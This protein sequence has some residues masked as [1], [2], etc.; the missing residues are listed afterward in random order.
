MTLLDWENVIG[1]IELV[2]FGVFGGIAVIK[3]RKLATSSK[4]QGKDN[5]DKPCNINAI[6]NLQKRSR[7]SIMVSLKRVCH[8]VYNKSRHHADKGDIKNNSPTHTH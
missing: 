3:L 2:V 7:Q 6:P 5:A 8:I 4:Y 1:L